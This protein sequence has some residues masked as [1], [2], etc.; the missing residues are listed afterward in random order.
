MTN[1]FLQET[2]IS[3]PLNGILHDILTFL[4]FLPHQICL[5]GVRI[6]KTVFPRIVFPDSIVDPLGFLIILT[7]FMILAKVAKKVAWAI[8][9]VGWILL[10]I[11]ILMII[12]NLG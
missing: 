1:L 8:V 12:F 5:A 3:K 10:L 9:V 2:A 4:Y 11:R 6:V 7:L